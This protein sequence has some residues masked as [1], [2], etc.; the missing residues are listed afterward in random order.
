MPSLT[1]GV[2]SPKLL[3]SHV[4][5]TLSNLFSVIMYFISFL[6]Y[7]SLLTRLA[8]NIRTIPGVRPFKL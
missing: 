4:K 7:K 5:A 2:K 1:L 6:N 3:L 8:F